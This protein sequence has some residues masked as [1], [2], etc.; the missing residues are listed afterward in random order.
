MDF[1]PIFLNLR[2]K[3]GLVV[4]GSEVA[5]RKA[6]LLLN[7]GARVT[8]VAPRLAE[9]FAQLEHPERLRHLAADFTPALLDDVDIVVCALRH[10]LHH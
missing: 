5:A 1:L 3:H 6:A 9:A 8:V 7:A 10:A 4:G 2:G